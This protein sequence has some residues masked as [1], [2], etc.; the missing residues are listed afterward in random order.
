MKKGDKIVLMTVLAL[1]VV[2]FLSVII[3]RISYKGKALNA[4][5][6]QNQKVLVEVDLEKIDE[7]KEW[8]VK[9]EEGHYNIIRV[10]KGRIRFIEANCPD[11]VCVHTGWLFQPGDIA[12]CMPHNVLVKIEGEKEELDE[13]SY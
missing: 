13:I 6:I 4:K 2:S 12:V 5:I 7:P 11:L 10:E 3:Y 1:L 9:G 8:M